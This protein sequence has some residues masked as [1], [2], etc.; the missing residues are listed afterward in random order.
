LKI[1]FAPEFADSLQKCFRSPWHPKEIWYRFKCWAWK[2]HTTVRPRWLDHT[3]CDRCELLPHMMFE[4]LGQF[5]EQEC[6]P[7]YVE[8][9]GEHGHKIEVNGE[10]KYVRDEMSDL[11]NWWRDTY[12]VGY[13]KRRDEIH[14]QIGKLDEESL[15]SQ[16]E[17]GD[18]EQFVTWN[19]R[20][21]TVEA[22]AAVKA[23]YAQLT[24]ID[25]EQRAA[26]AERMHRLVNIREYLWT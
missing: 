18:G 1:A 2:R 19:P 8:W 12:I 25:N 17:Q 22:A 7:G 6:S 24:A 26:L 20:Y 23:H 5:I 11:W 16:F 21:K 13:D 3:W 15:I 4:I 14:E 9:Y 10:Q